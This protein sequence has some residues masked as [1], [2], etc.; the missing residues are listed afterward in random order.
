MPIKRSIALQ[1]L[2]RQHHNG[3]LF[4]LLLGKGVKRNASLFDMQQ[5]IQQFREQDLDS[6]FAAEEKLLLPL[7][8]QYPGLQP[9]LKQMYAEHILLVDLMETIDRRPDYESILQLSRLLEKHIRFEEKVLFTSIENV[10]E[11]EKLLQIQ[12]ALHHEAHTSNCMTYPVKF[13]EK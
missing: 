8:E 10:I 2:S 3:L 13:W 1:P 5:F 4:C 6:H 9:L 7:A 11:A 12:E